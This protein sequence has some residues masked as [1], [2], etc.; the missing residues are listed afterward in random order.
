MERTVNEIAERAGI[1]GRTIRHYHQ[2]GLLLPDRVGSNGYRYYGPDAVARLQRILLLRDTG[3]P[4]TEIAAA[5]EM[6]ATPETEI[7]ALTGHLDQLAKERETLDR[8]INAVQHTLKM[9]RQGGQPRIDVMLEG[10][11]DR[12]EA[13]VVARWGRDAF[14]ASNQ[15]WHRK[16]LHQQREWKTRSEALLARWRQIQE[17]GHDAD[18]EAAQAHASVHA[19]WFKEIPG[20]PTHAGDTAKS[21]DMI[22]GLADQYETNTEFHVAFG[23]ADAAG[24]AASALRLHVRNVIASSR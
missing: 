16:S 22:C 14:E 9:R 11:N 15:W 6:S 1:S 20:T 7:E 2:I 17:E 12:Y 8:R 24:F 19:Q 23:T 18:S 10:F 13:E 4:L 5:L 21:L 3:M